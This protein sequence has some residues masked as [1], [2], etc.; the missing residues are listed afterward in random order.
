MFS[1]AVLISAPTTHSPT[2]L[3]SQKERDYHQTE[4]QING[5]MPCENGRGEP[6]FNRNFVWVWS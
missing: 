4:E 1:S 3:A 6:P 2:I 5:A